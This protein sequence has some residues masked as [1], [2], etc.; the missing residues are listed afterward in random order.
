MGKTLCSLFSAFKKESLCQLYIYPSLPDVDCCNSCYRIT[1]KNILNFFRTL[2][3]EGKEI[4]FES[5]YKTFHK[6]FENPKDEVLYRNKK[7]HSAIRVLARDVLWFIV[8]WFNKSLKIWLLNEKITHI[9]VAPGDSKFIYDIALKCSK[10]LNVPIITYLCDEYFFVAQPKGLLKKIKVFLQRRKMVQLLKKTSLIVTISEE[11][12]NLYEPFFKIKTKVLYTATS[13]PISQKPLPRFSINELTYM[14]NIRLNRFKSLCDIGEILDDINQEYQTNFTLKI[15]SPEKDKTILSSLSKHQSIKLMNFV[16][17]DQFKN[18]FYS[19]QC[20]L[21][22]EAFDECTIDYI[23]NSISTKIADCLG[24]G[25]LLA[26]YGPSSIASM[27]H[28]IRNN[29]AL[30]ADNKKELKNMLL[31]IFNMTEKE[32]S[33]IIKN[34]LATANKCHKADVNGLELLN[35]ISIV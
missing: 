24:S 35:T 22:V 20:F 2:K 18:T 32:R 25:I 6:L 7:N 31:K 19:T 9:F 1:D 12:K 13:F 14:G 27:K 3:V 5:K 26:A 11:L 33:A 17:G 15:Y 30:V 8:P 16:T 29:C 28:L 4:K 23:K 21:H 10:F 34:A